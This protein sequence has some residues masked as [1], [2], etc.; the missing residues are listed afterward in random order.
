MLA[1]LYALAVASATWAG[2]NDNV[3]L[4][5]SATWCGPCQQMSPLVSK[6]ERQGLPIRK[7]DVDRDREL[8]QQFGISSI[9]AF[10]LVVNGKVVDRVVGATSETKLREMLA[11]I[12]KDNSAWEYANAAKPPAAK[13]A[14]NDKKAPVAPEVIRAKLGDPKGEMKAGPLAASV[15]IRVRDSNGENFGSG[16][17]IDSRI[18]RTLIVTCGHIFR[19]LEKNSSIEVDVFTT[20]RPETY[21][22]KVVRYD[23]DADVGLI[24]IPSDVLPACRVAAPG[25][26]ILKGM[27]VLSVG[28]G[29]GEPPSEQKH[30]VTALNLFLGPDNIEC[31]GVPVQGRSGGGL[32]TNEGLLI[33]IC[34]AAD[35]RYEQ[36][37][38]AGLK[39][40]HQLLDQCQLA[41]LYQPVPRSENA[42][43]V[44]T[45]ADAPLFV[46]QA[47]ATEEPAAEMGEEELVAAQ[48]SSETN[49]ARHEAA[50]GEASEALREALAGV[51][52]AEVVCVIRPIGQP[53]SASR[54]V[55]IN[56]ASPRFVSYLTDEVGAQAEVTTLTTPPS[57]A[58][59]V[60]ALK[61][62]SK[63]QTPAPQAYRRS[64]SR[65]D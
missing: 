40:V 25:E 30:R 59:N 14:S 34:N 9:P 39:T 50:S 65:M 8:A 1:P 31:S 23:L 57:P 55:V 10:V 46:S 37:M 12:P 21:D 17:I 54:V 16:T 62:V 32:F 51:G 43:Q 61:P 56:R 42:V 26:R 4:D 3:L 29:G 33:G 45:A 15:R 7:V 24:S 13:G 27:P 58:K 44:A 18:G 11:R 6:L 41:H 60:S 52:H 22:G 64:K 49:E 47:G 48:V 2:P 53:Q 63:D 38:Y 28:C 36:G 20:G 19:H 5:F 35:P